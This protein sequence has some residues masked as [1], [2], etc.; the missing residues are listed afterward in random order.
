MGNA[1]DEV[2]AA[3]TA[4]AASYNEEG[5]AKALGRFVLGEDR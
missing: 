3:A 4:V 5:F 2:K 1:P